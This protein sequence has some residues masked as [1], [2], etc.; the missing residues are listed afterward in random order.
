MFHP[1]AIFN[2]CCASE[3]GP[4][5]SHFLEAALSQQRSGQN[6]KKKRNKC[7]PQIFDLSEKLSQRSGG[8]EFHS[9]QLVH[10]KRGQDGQT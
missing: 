6:A 9:G 2:Q 1:I 4:L 5:L 3:Q 7:Q 8:L 10:V